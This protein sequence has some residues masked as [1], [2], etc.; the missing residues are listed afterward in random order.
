MASKK[1]S[2]LAGAL[3][4]LAVH[5]FS[6]TATT[7]G[8]YDASDSSIVP[9]RRMPQHTE[10]MNGTYNYPAK[11]RNQWE[12]GL[13]V[14]S[15]NILGDVP[16][17]F[18]G[19][20][21]GVHL[22]KALGYVFSLR[23]EYMNATARG[24][25]WS[26]ATNYSQNPA[27]EGY[28]GQPVYYNH[29]TSLND[30]AI[31]GIASLNNIRFH[32][33]K[34]GVNPYL[35]A[36]FG[37]TTYQARVN[38]LNDEGGGGLYTFPTSTA[39]YESRKE[40]RDQLKDLM[41][42]SYETAA[43]TDGNRRPKFLGVT[44]VPALHLGA[45]IAFKLNNRFNLAIEDRLS[46]TRS[47]LLDG[48]QWAEQTP[49]NP[50]FTRTPD[51]YNYL[52]VG[53]NIN[54]GAKATEPLWWV[55]PLDYAYSEIRNPRL[56][57]LPKPVLP[58]ADGDGVTDQ[59][60]L[61]QTP[62]GVPVD[63][64]GVSRDTDGDGVPDCRDKELVTPTMC[65]PVDADGVGSCPRPACCDSLGVRTSP[66]DAALGQLPSVTFSGNGVALSNDAKGLLASVAARMRQ[67]PDCRVV[68][69]GYCASS[70]SE[71]QRSW[72]RVNAV[73]NYLVESEGLNQERFIF[74]YGQEGGDCN[75]VDLRAATA[76]EQGQATVPAPHPNLRRSK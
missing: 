51:S 7:A 55:N 14:G 37:F 73:I 6:Q 1:Y 54:L 27:W 24:L 16:S 12:L 26:P 30:F 13:K 10:F 33:A 41:D 15:A 60:D 71:Q 75:T 22:R 23:F 11:P 76:D 46:L 61:E 34:T 35:L 38:K 59:F 20:G 8:G 74:Q 28:T 52:T 44:G 9:S 3:C 48:Q 42:D 64:H 58:D 47:D 21:Y 40:I 32:K 68:V 62:Q 25:N 49:G 50:V 63:S 18:P 69:V 39:T 4:L 67:N 43:E 66:C 53:L 36:G 45:G 19:F 31:E 70:K 65:Q 5:G 17:Q 56:M 57:R 72:D 2:F 29:K